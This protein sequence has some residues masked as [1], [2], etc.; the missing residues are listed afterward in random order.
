MEF[1]QQE[2]TTTSSSS[3]K[4]QGGQSPTKESTMI[5]EMPQKPPQSMPLL[6][7]EGTQNTARG[8]T[9]TPTMIEMIDAT[10]EQPLPCPQEFSNATMLYCNDA[11]GTFWLDEEKGCQQSDADA[12]CKLKLCDA[13]AISTSYNITEDSN[14]PGFAC[15]GHGTNF[16]DW[17][18]MTDVWFKEDIRSSH[19]GG[20]VVSEVVCE[21][22]GKSGIN[23]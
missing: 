14:N 20:S 17:F 4:T 9:D 7:E 2:Q 21:K 22:T 15:R 1:T 5:V 12:Y 16:G 18:G 6:I 10:T 8:P 13:D 11:C 19:H 23:I 3:E